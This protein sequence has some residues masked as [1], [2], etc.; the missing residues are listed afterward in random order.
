[1]YVLN[2]TSLKLSYYNSG[3]LS[4]SLGEKEEQ[5]DILPQASLPKAT[6]TSTFSHRIWSASAVESQ[7]KAQQTYEV[8]CANLPQLRISTLVW[9]L[10][11]LTMSP[12]A[13]YKM[14]PGTKQ[15]G[16]VWSGGP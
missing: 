15:I 12:A 5:L 7:L 8:F 9:N 13:S 10:L 4:S 16:N 14:C 1:M 2:S 11:K 3:R 6:G